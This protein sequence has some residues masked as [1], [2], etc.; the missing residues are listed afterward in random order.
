MNTESTNQSARTEGLPE[1]RLL[2]P[3]D[4]LRLEPRPLDVP[5]NAELLLS[6]TNPEY[7]S[8]FARVRLKS[9]EDLQALGFVP[10]TLAEEKVRQAMAADDD[11]GYDLAGKMLQQASGECACS[12]EATHAATWRGSP[13]RGV[14]NR[15]R[16]R[17]NPAL[18]RVLADHYF[19]HMA[20]DSPVPAIVRK[21]VVALSLR[22]KPESLVAL[23]GNITVHKNATLTVAASSNSL[24]AWNIW[25]HTTGRLVGQGSYL[26]IWTNSL[27]HFSNFPNVAAV[28]AAKKTPP[29][30][31]IT[32]SE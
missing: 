21:W 9:Y 8:C 28:D 16:K 20:W 12:R 11:E 27:N 17:H 14:Y 26:K 23:L 13:I 24:M 5:E 25:I 29:L 2:T 30:W 4:V 31:T 22:L 7:A 10:R 19:T 1:V 3:K 18:A 32:E 6:P 15:I